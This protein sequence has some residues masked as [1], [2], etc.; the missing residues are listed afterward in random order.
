VLS[1]ARNLPGLVKLATEGFPWRE[2]VDF[3]ADEWRFRRTYE[4]FKNFTMVPERVYIENLRLAQ[5]VM[6][7]SGSIV[8]CGTWR[9]GMIAGIAD[10]LGPSRCYHLFDSFQGLPPVTDID[11]VEAREWQTSKSA[12]DHHNNCTA[13]EA[14]ARTA[15]SMSEATDYRITPGWF[16]ETL[17]KIRPQEPIALL[18]LDADWYESTKCILDNLSAFVA[19]GGMIIVDD[20]FTWEGCTHAVNEYATRSKRRIRQWSNLELCYILV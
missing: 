6:R 14:E 10:T 4:K 18:R 19:P 9:G 2:R 7:T 11:G 8:E 20:Y 5:R 13:S 3:A 1:Y 16:A 17:P 12:S 15:M